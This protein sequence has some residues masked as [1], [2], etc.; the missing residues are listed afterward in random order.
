MQSSKTLVESGTQGAADLTAYMR[1]SWSQIQA[2]LPKDM[3]AKEF[4]QLVLTEIRNSDIQKAS[5]VTKTAL[6]ECSPQSIIGAVFTAA[7]LGLKIGP[8]GE[9]Y[10]VPYVVK[11]HAEAKLIPGYQGLAKLALQHPMVASLDVETVYPGDE[12]LYVKGSNPHI[13]HTPRHHKP[14]EQPMC[15]Y[16][17]VWLTNGKAILKV[18]YPDEIQELRRGKVGPSG[19]IPDPQHWMEKKV[20]LKQALKLAPKSTRLGYT[21]SQ[22]DTPQTYTIDSAQELARK[23]AAPAITPTPQPI[24]TI[25]G[26]IMPGDDPRDFEDVYTDAQG[27]LS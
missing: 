21:L 20:V 11:G 4:V 10:L 8:L 2:T 1:G 13:D 25:T 7:S 18:L 9:A 6:S 14:G 26:E 22:D 19:D 15:Y 24:D 27:M 12:F 23:S 3:D 5:G 16:A 17:I